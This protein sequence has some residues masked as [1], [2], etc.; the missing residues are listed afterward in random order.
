MSY[1]FDIQ[2][3]HA[4]ARLGVGKAHDEMVRIVVEET[5]RVYPTHI[6][7]RAFSFYL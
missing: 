4:I 1:V 3:L 6:D 7:S 5:A 2:K